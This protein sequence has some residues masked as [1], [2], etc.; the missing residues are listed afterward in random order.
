VD[1]IEMRRQGWAGH[2]TRMEH[3]RTLK[4]VLHMKFI[5]K[6]LVGKPGTRWE[7]VVQRDTL[8]ILGIRGWGRRAE[9]GE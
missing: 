9:D 1:D 7:D 3:K 5:T 2:I 4:K 8:Q 6:T